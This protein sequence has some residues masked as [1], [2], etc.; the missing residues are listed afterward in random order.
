MKK[1]IKIN[2][3]YKIEEDLY[4]EIKKAFDK[5]NMKMGTYIR[6]CL[7]DF[8]EKERGKDE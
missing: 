5:K 4:L 3:S 1:K 8:Y 6:N 2:R 7:I